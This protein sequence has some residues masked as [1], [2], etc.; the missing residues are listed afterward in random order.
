[1]YTMQAGTKREKLLAGVDFCFFF[2]KLRPLLANVVLS[3]FAVFD[4]TTGHARVQHTRISTHLCI[5]LANI[6]VHAKYKI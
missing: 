2:W 4:T 3:P 1:M 5:Y 6:D